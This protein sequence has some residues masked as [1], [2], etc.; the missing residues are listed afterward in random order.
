M[1]ISGDEH[2][3]I[4]KRQSKEGNLKIA[5]GCEP[6]GGSNEVKRVPIDLK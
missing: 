4:L 2:T 6:D 5:F 3:R 1:L